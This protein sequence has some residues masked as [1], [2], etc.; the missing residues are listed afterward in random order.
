MFTT[1]PPRAF[2]PFMYTP[3]PL[4]SCTGNGS[5]STSKNLGYLNE[6]LIVGGIW[7]YSLCTNNDSVVLQ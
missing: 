4:L 7:G 6:A 5:I 2:V 3:Y 1:T